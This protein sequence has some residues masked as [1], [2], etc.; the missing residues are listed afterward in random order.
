MDVRTTVLTIVEK[1]T[2]KADVKFVKTEDVAFAS[3]VGGFIYLIKD[4]E[5]P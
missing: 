4:L 3:G 1:F 2:M 5:I